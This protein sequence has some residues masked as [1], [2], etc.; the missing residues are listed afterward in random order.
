MNRRE[1][2]PAIAGLLALPAV[3]VTA[4]KGPDLQV[5]VVVPRGAA[6]NFGR[7]ICCRTGEDISKRFPAAAAQRLRR[8]F[9]TRRAI[10]VHLFRLRDGI[11][12]IEGATIARE[13][14]TVLVSSIEEA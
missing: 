10:R 1:A 2:L 4:D 3:F 11:P 6:L 5:R 7:V 8:S 14:K 13:M 9:V 12:Y